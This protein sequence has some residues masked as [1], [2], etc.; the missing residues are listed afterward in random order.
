[1][2]VSF[3]NIILADLSFPSPATGVTAT[4]PGAS[5]KLAGD[6]LPRFSRHNYNCSDR[7]KLGSVET[8]FGDDFTGSGR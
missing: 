3:F 2:G 7:G 8:E 1:M 5:C 4:D 6:C